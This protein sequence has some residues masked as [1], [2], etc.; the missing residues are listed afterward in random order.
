M[1]DF[2][3]VE[4]ETLARTRGGARILGIPKDTGD[5]CDSSAS[6]LDYPASSE[7]DP[8]E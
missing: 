7:L 4:R 2:Q 6:P 8:R 1:G 5:N 3:N